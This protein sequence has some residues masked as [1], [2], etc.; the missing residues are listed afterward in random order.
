[1]LEKSLA[2][3]LTAFS[4]HLVYLAFHIE[5]YT[6]ACLSTGSCI[7]LVLRTVPTWYC[8]LVMKIFQRSVEGDF[9]HSGTGIMKMNEV[10]FQISS[11]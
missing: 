7:A 9:Y 6:V 4:A 3:L 2:S 11:R 5:V 1:M 10:L 8:F